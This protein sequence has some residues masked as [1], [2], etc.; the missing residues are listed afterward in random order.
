MSDTVIEI[1]AH[2]D[3]E[4]DEP[5]NRIWPRFRRNISI[6][7]IGVGASIFLKLV[8]VVILTKFLR[9][10]DYGRVLI[11]TNLMVFLNSFLGLRVN[12]AILRFFQPMKEQ[13]DIAGIRRLL[14][15]CVGICVVSCLVIVLAIL[16]LSGW[17][18][19]NV[20]SDSTLSPLFQVFAITLFASSFSGVYEP[21]LRLH[22]RFSLLVISQVLGG[23]ITVGALYV[24]FVS[25]NGSDYDLRLV[26]VAIA[27]GLLVQSIPPITK[28]IQLLKPLLS[29]KIRPH[30][31]NNFRSDL[32]RCLF[33]S[34]LAGYLKF[35]TSPG[36]IFL[37]GLF[38]TPGQVALYGIARQC[39]APIAILEVTL[40]T[41]IT[42]EIILLRARE[43]L[44]Q[45]K[46]LIARYVL[47]SGLLSAS[48]L[49]VALVL[50]RTLFLWFFPEQYSNALPVFY[51]LIIASSILLILLVFRPLAVTLDL[52][53]W[54]NFALAVSVCLLLFL[55]CT[56]RLNSMTMAYVQLT[57]AALLRPAFSFLVWIRLR[58]RI[59][60]LDVRH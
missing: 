13:D 27:I 14:L 35:A 18:A 10:D 4:C 28:T 45:L 19:H 54:H 33:N 17:L 51:C 41:A 31:A 34:N 22:D 30:P 29:Q 24:Y 59:R 58:D 7:V 52:L 23:V 44:K 55:I 9:I 1:D 56:H 16:T 40:Q 47:L 36:D 60:L 37:L 12:D 5:Q 8:Q 50:G 15:I 11:A 43:R 6:S 21:I 42:P 20:Y 26:M 2:Q 38:S 3:E 48:L 25:T 46:N 49:L 53:K 57:E 32:V 39:A